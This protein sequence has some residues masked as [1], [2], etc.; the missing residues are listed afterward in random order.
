MGRDDLLEVI[1][2]TLR[3]EP[4]GDKLEYFV[5]QHPPIRLAFPFSGIDRDGQLCL[6]VSDAARFCGADKSQI[7]RMVKSGQLSGERHERAV[8]VPLRELQLYKPN[9]TKQAVGRIG[10]LASQA[11]R[12][13][14]LSVRRGANQG[15]GVDLLQ[16]HPGAPAGAAARRSRCS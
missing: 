14:W 8:M 16:S 3:K 10:G 9:A 7:S 6:S 15:A 1:R 13:A 11:M 4:G 5:S 12:R 2:A